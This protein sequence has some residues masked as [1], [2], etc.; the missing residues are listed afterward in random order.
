MK[1]LFMG[2][3]E[4][5]RVHLSA[6][7]SSKHEVAAV[8]TQPDK[9]TGRKK[10][11]T[12]PPVKELANEC[13]IPVYQ[14]E[15]LSGGA[16]Q[17]ILD[18]VA[19]EV[20][21]VV[22]YGKIL[23]P[24]I[25]SYPVYGCI[26]VHGSLLPRYRGAAPVQRAIL[27]GETETGVTVMYMDEGMDTGDILLQR[28][29]PIDDTDDQTTL[30]EKMAPVGV[31]ALLS[32]LDAVEKGTAT[33]IKQNDD[34]ATYAAMLDKETGHI[35]WSGSERSVLCRVRG[36]FPW[37]I[38]YSFYGGKK[39]RILAAGSGKGSG[40]PGEVLTASPAEGLTVACGSGAVRLLTVQEDGGNKMAAED[41]L[42]GHAF[43][44]G[45][46]FGDVDG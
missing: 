35:D 31:E 16:I 46:R 45:S 8:I 39:L 19:P 43:Q 12:A 29:L 6:L 32:A 28:T 14:P 33:R 27:D 26:N 11:L 40:A 1:I 44:I 37:P 41:Y 3:P 17:G 18:D 20:I 15:K 42:R 22:A 2:T 7:L 38:A 34:E 24:Y 5:A 23:P 4:F 25:L 36:A 30:F 9:P 10:I 21:V 13:G